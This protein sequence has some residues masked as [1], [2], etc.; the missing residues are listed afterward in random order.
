MK[1][2][3]TEVNGGP[4]EM[5]DGEWIEIGLGD[6]GWLGCKLQQPARGITCDDAATDERTNDHVQQLPWEPLANHSGPEITLLC[7][8]TYCTVTVL[9]LPNRAAR[10]RQ[11]D[12]TFLVNCRIHRSA[13]RRASCVRIIHNHNHG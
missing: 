1:C 5:A 9:V 13:V 2:E 11:A 12:R 10:L 6:S 4:W 7:Y 3:M 8:L